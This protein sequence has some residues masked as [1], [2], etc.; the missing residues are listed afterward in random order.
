MSLSAREEDKDRIVASMEAIFQ[1]L[2]GDVLETLRLSVNELGAETERRIDALREETQGS[3][4]ALRTELLSADDS[5]K[6]EA[7][8]ELETRANLMAEHSKSR[9]ETA[10][11]DLSQ[12]LEEVEERLQKDQLSI[13]ERLDGAERGLMRHDEASSRITEL[14]DTLGHVLARDT[15]SQKAEAITTEV[16]VELA[17]PTPWS[18]IETQPVPVGGSN[19]IDTEEMEGALDRVDLTVSMPTTPHTSE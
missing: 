1:A 14:L 16:E 2:L 8:T 11:R 17:E 15:G 6:R 18:E 7:L 12:R 9:L 5:V 10:R 3:L 4:E 13:S 19:P